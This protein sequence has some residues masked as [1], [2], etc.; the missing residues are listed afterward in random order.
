MIN[1][2]PARESLVGDIPAGDGKIV[3]LFYS[4]CFWVDRSLLRG[5]RH[6][7]QICRD[8]FKLLYINYHS[9]FKTSQIIV[10]VF[11]PV[12]NPH[13]FMTISRKS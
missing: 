4:V 1:L 13:R 9:M 2:F 11:K 6:G 5:N 8:F 7:L 3:N 10:I 12:F